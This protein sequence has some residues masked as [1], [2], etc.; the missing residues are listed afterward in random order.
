MCLPRLQGCL[1]DLVLALV[2]QLLAHVAYVGDVLDVDDLVALD[3][4]G[5][6]HP[7]RHEV[8]T[9]VPDVD[10]AVDCGP[11]GVHANG[12]RLVETDLLNLPRQGVEQTHHGPAAWC[13]RLWPI[14]CHDSCA[15]KIARARNK[16]Q[17]LH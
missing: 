7:I 4:Q 3:L 2:H 9:E 11:A 10:G 1:D 8:G 17:A 5:P 15:F 12:A 6:A 13:W 16:E 14:L